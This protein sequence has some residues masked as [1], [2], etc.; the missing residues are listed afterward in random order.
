MNDCDLTEGE[1][2]RLSCAAVEA[3]FLPLLGVHRSR[4]EFLSR[5][6]HAQL[7]GNRADFLRPVAIAVR[8][9]LCRDRADC[10]DR[11][12][13]AQR[14]VGVLPVDFETPTL[15]RADLLIPQAIDDATLARAVTG[16]PLRVIVRMRAGV[17]S[18]KRRLQRMSCGSCAVRVPP[19]MA[20][21]VKA[22]VKSLRDLRIGDAKTAAW[23]L[24]GAVLAVLML[25]SSNVAN[26]L[27]A[28]NVA[29]PNEMSVRRA[30][31]AGRMRLLRQALTESL[32][33]S[34][35]GGIAGCVV[36]Y[37][38]VTILGKS[39]PLGIPQI[40]QAAVDTRV[41]DVVP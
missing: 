10:F 35:L 20:R 8:R 13:P 15:A 3:T 17:P 40:A 6:G 9:R 34:I 21:E 11:R 31:G 22:H 38:L 41:L 12:R 4:A 27:L 24:F 26:L 25:A 2:V 36:A 39:A 19:A 37:A 18:P 16:R 29:L 32:V 1:P 28:R 23:V 33:I 5:G 30:L 14:V 7:T